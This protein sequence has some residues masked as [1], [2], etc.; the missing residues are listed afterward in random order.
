MTINRKIVIKPKMKIKIFLNPGHDPKR[1]PPEPGAVH[2]TRG[3]RECDIALEIGKR[4]QQ[5]LRMQGIECYLMQDDDLSKVCQAANALRA[6]IFISIHCNASDKHLA[7][8]TEI[9]YNTR[10]GKI[11]AQRVQNNILLAQPRAIDRGV[12]QTDNF[13]VLNKTYMPSILIET[14]FIDNDEDEKLLTKELDK[15]VYGIT[16]GIMVY[17]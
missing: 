9:W 10:L 2:P 6:N 12:K 4:V 17:L 11:L 15:Y 13:Y 1:N 14:A 8:G 5:N 3:T 7:R 16:R